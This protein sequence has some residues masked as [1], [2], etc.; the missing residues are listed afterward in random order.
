MHFATTG[1]MPA[2]QPAPQERDSQSASNA[3]HNGSS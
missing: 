2:A 1:K 3:I